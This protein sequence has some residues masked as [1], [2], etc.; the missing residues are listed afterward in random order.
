MQTH[1]MPSE[2]DQL[3]G[4]YEDPRLPLS[5]YTGSFEEQ[6]MQ[7]DF[8]HF[9]SDDIMTKVDRASMGVSLEGREPLLDH[10]LIEFAFR[11]PLHLRIGGLG[12]KHLLRKVLYR[13][14]PRN[15]IDRPKQGFTIPINQWMR[16]D[17]AR[18]VQGLLSSKSLLQGMLDQ[19]IVR[20]EVRLLQKTS[21][22]EIRV[23]RMFVC[24]Q[25]MNAWP[26]Q[27]EVLSVG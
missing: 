26:S 7:W 1:F 23:W 24:L 12:Q 11:L 6:M 14:V 27:G 10:R 22:N 19:E 20:R 5:A 2:I 16:E 4:G 18:M 17:N 21:V 9:L 25:W 8:Q 3:I 13:Y 15:L